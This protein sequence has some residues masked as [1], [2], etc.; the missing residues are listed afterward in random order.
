MTTVKATYA[1]NFPQ[2]RIIGFT[3]SPR[4][5]ATRVTFSIARAGKRILW[6]QSKRLISGS[7]VVLTPSDDMFQKKSVVAT[8]A[9]RPVSALQQNPP[10]LDLFIART[11]ELEIDPAVEWVM[12]EARSSFYEAER[13]TMLAL[14]KMMSE[15]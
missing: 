7:L 2:V 1:D 8:I 3:C 6:E 14:Q 4:G 15:P 11:A 10:E 9:A 13:H 12:V 5:L